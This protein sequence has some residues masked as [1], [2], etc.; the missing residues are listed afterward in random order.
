M[1]LGDSVPLLLQRTATSLKPGR[2]DPARRASVPGPLCADDAQMQMSADDA[3]GL[4]PTWMLGCTDAGKT[5]N[6]PLPPNHNQSKPAAI[7]AYDPDSAPGMFRAHLVIPITR[8]QL[9]ILHC[10]PPPPGPSL[11]LACR[12]CTPFGCESI[13]RP[14]C[15]HGYTW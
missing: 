3:Q 9:L 10:R 11:S 1:A 12:R 6:P 15:S 7:N 8:I 13:V 5:H 2:H 14:G 4:Q